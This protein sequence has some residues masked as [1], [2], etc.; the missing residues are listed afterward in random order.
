M[1]AKS[2]GSAAFMSLIC[3][4]GGS[5]FSTPLTAQEVCGRPVDRPIAQLLDTM[6][7]TEN[8]S[9]VS[10]DKQFVVLQ[11]KSGQYWT[12]TVAGHSA[13]PSVACRRLQQADGNFFVRTEL[14]CQ[15]AEPACKKLLAD[16]QLLDQRMQEAIRKDLQKK[17]SP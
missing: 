16:F 1:K 6:L 13:H 8:A 17:K 3:A 2:R 12:F 15:A 14:H 5:L 4:V 9:S 11:D 10:R 7:K